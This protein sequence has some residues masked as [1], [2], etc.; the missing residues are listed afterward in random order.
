[1]LISSRDIVLALRRTSIFKFGFY[2]TF[3]NSIEVQ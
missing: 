3:L 1:M 2:W